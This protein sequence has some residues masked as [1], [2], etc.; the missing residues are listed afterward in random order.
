[1]E[2]IADEKKERITNKI[3][4]TTDAAVCLKKKLIFNETKLFIFF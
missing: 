4:K 3:N 2:R 1:M